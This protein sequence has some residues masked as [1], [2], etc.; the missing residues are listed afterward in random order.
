MAGF[1][2]GETD[3]EAFVEQTAALGGD[4]LNPV[5]DESEAFVIVF[6]DGEIFF[7]GA[8]TG[9]LFE[10]PFF[11]GPCA[12]DAG[13]IGLD[14]IE[15]DER[16][17]WRAEGVLF[18]VVAEG[19]DSAGFAAGGEAPCFSER[20]AQD[21]HDLVKRFKFAFGPEGDVFVVFVLSEA[22]VFV[23]GE[24]CSGFGSF[25]EFLEPLGFSAGGD[26]DFGDEFLDFLGRNHHADLAA[27]RGFF[28][29]KAFEY[30]GNLGGGKGS[31]K[32]EQQDDFHGHRR[33]GAVVSGE[34]QAAMQAIGFRRGAFHH[35]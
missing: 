28:F 19:G 2:E 13:G 4:F 3:D 26:F 23:E 12:E 5:N 20:L 32:A 9:V 27:N 15:S 22:E 35:K 8:E 31:E 6:A 11:T 25:G 7:D 17:I 10:A 24:G 30:L 18:G 33:E 1:T 34:T 16:A 14:V 29:E 21:E